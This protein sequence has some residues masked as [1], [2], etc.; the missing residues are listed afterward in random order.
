MSAPM[1]RALLREIEQPG[2]GK[3]QMR[4]LAWRE[5]RTV[6]AAE[7]DGLVGSNDGSLERRGWQVIDSPGDGIETWGKPTIWQSVKPGDRLWV[8]ETWGTGCRPC[9]INGWRDGI[10]Y[11]A[12]EA[13]LDGHDDLTLY[14]VNTPDDVHLDDY[15]SGWRPSIHMPRW[16]SRITLLVT[17]TKME[18][19]QQ[20]SRDD[21][22]AEGIGWQSFPGGGA[23][24]GESWIYSYGLTWQSLHTKP[25]TRWADNP[26]V[27]AITF[28]PVLANIDQCKEAR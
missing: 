18:R 19:V 11:R 12:D 6:S 5:R 28:R 26:E 16:A 24:V 10:E 15:P 1:V 22:V 25:G 21:A 20:I 3:T 7:A 9:P 14:D 8:R 13:Y 17:A 4:R 23:T 27:V 2:T